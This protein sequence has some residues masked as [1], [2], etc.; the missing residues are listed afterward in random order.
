MPS[1]F[2]SLKIAS[3]I[4]L[5]QNKKYSKCAIDD[6]TSLDIINHRAGVAQLVE[7]RTRNAQVSGPSPDTGSKDSK[8]L[9]N[10]A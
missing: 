7:Q 5:R 10:Y 8:G 4:V 6:G 1:S 3:N 9:R 2:I